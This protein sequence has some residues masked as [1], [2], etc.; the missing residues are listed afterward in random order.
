MLSR[1]PGL[2]GCT[3]WI[4]KDFRSPRR[5]LK[6]IQDDFNRKGVISDHGE[7][8]KAFYIMQEWYGKLKEEYR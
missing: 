3:P 1:I 6:D 4:L 7:K 2:A 8:K 5:Q